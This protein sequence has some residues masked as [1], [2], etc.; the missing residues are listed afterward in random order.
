[1]PRIYLKASALRP[2]YTWLTME[3]IRDS[4]AL[5]TAYRQ[6]FEEIFEEIR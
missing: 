1:M 5:P 6:F 3:E 4:A 2:E